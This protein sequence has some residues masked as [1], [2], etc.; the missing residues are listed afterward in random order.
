M[1]ET[2]AARS[3]LAE[4]ALK[5][6]AARGWRGV[7]LHELASLARRP[8]TDF[9]PLTPADASDCIDEY[10]DRAAGESAPAPN[11]EEPARERVFDVAMRRFEAMEPHRAGLLALEQALGFDPIGQT[12]AFARLTRTARWLLALAGEER[13]GVGAAARAQALAFVLRQTRAAWAKDD[14]GDFAKTMAALDKGLRRADE[15]FDSVGK[16]AAGLRPGQ[17]RAKPAD[18]AP[19]SDH[20]EATSPG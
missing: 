7:T 20:P 9:Y 11:G 5:R 3:A 14:L 10:F 13:E 2:A 15:F 12:A 18:E 4:A 1:S 16:V 8:V 6:A 17:T 19:P